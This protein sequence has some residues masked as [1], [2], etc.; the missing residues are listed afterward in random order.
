MKSAYFQWSKSQSTWEGTSISVGWKRLW[1]LPIPHKIRVFLWRL[2]RNTIP[3][4]YRLHGLG[5]PVTISC[6]MC[7]DEVEHLRHLFFEC[8]FSKECWQLM[9][10]NFEAHDMEHVSEWL[11]SFLASGAV[12]WG[13]WYARNKCVFDNKTM[14]PGIVKSWCLKQVSD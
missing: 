7:V 5:L 6:P 11:V 4:R 2:C 13:I 1:R 8:S 3:V 9:G 12:L 10:L 14:S